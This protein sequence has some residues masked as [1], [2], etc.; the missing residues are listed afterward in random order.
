MFT[1]H[2]GQN[3][4]LHLLR[5]AEQVRAWLDETPIRISHTFVARRWDGRRPSIGL[6]LLLLACASDPWR[7][8][9]ILLVVKRCMAMLLYIETTLACLDLR[10]LLLL[11]TL[12]V[13]VDRVK[14]F[15]WLSMFLWKIA[16]IEHRDAVAILEFMK[17]LRLMLKECFTMLFHLWLLFVR[18]IDLDSDVFFFFLRMKRLLV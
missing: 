12:I 15:V 18:R 10:L 2:L 16:L 8:G 6:V 14:S 4:L 11:F 3:A 1:T 7:I 17:H 13:R 5:P 9:V